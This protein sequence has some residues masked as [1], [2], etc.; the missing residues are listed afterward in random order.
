MEALMA[1]KER[2][3][4]DLIGCFEDERRFLLKVDLDALAGVS[5][6]KEAV[7]MTLSALND[8]IRCTARSESPDIGVEPRQ[9]A[10]GEL[11]SSRRSH[12]EHLQLK[13]KGLER[14]VAL[15]RMENR[16]IINES[17][18]FLDDLLA[19]LTGNDAKKE[20][21]DQTRRVRPKKQPLLIHR[22]V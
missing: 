9:V 22:E 18:E 3:L 5:R 4:S 13:L 7:A 1:E 15:R 16:A 20:T 8:K 10:D 6:R 12:F 2:C 17:I 19:I 21:Y 14:D 11:K